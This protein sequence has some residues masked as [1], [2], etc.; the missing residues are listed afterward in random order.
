[1]RYVSGLIAALAAAMAQSAVARPLERE[2]P[3][4]R[5]ACWERVYDA[6]H[7]SAHPRQKVAGI[8]LVHI[9]TAEDQG[10][11]GVYLQLYFNL[12]QR[13][14]NAGT[15]HDYKYGGFCKA[16][17]F[18]LRCEAEWDAGVFTVEPGQRGDLLVRNRGIVANP[19]E[20]DSE[21]IADNAVKIPAKPD[22]GA[23]ALKPAGSECKIE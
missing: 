13:R 20:Y 8:R 22:D 15:A 14:G 21:D 11:A 19:L 4:K 2:L 7:L 1:M 23:W 5:A 18:G 17:G 9:A 10:P 6:A 16:A 12:R 3:L